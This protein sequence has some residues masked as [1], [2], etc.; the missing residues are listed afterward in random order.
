MCTLIGKAKR[1]DIDPQAWLV[2]ILERM[3]GHPVRHLQELLP[4]HW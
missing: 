3:A 4:W 2:D 1:N